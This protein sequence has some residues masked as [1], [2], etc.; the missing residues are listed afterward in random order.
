MPSCRAYDAPG[1]RRPCGAD[2]GWTPRS[3]WARIRSRWT[4]ESE[5]GG[6][7]PLLTLRAGSPVP[8]AREVVNPAALPPQGLGRVRNVQVRVRRALFSV[9]AAALMVGLALVPGP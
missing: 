6:T 1:R 4:E 9:G 5:H 2:W 3:L 8:V 7:T